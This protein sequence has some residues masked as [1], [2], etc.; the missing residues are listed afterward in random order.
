[1][2][3][4]EGNLTLTLLKDGAGH[5]VPTSNG[6]AQWTAA[7]PAL[8]Y[9]QDDGN[10]ITN[11]SGEPTDLGSTP[12][13]SWSWG[14]APDGQGVEAYVTHDLLYRT[15]GTCFVK[16]VS[17]RTRAQPYTRAEADAILRDGLKLCGVS[18]VRRNLIWAA[19]RAGGSPDWGS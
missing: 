16:G 4:F 5:P 10:R 3:W 13:W 18:T 15:A 19:V 11:P 14:F 9:V 17:Y 7:P 6:R 1:M 12:E 8:V 2:S